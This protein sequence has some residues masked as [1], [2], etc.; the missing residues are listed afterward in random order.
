MSPSTFNIT[1]IMNDKHLSGKSQSQEQSLGKYDVICG[2]HKDAFDNVGNRRFRVLI[3]LSVSKYVHAPSR[4][5]KSAVIKDIVDSIHTAGGRFL[6]RPKGVSTCKW[7]ELDEKQTYD[8]IGH[9]FRDMSV[10]LKVNPDKRNVS[11]QSQ[12]SLSP[13]T[14]SINLNNVRSQS[15]SSVSQLS[16]TVK[17]PGFISVETNSAIVDVSSHIS[18]SVSLSNYHTYDE[19]VQPKPHF[20]MNG[21]DDD[22]I[23]IVLDGDFEDWTYNSMSCSLAFQQCSSQDSTRQ[24]QQ[25]RDS[26]S[27]FAIAS[28]LLLM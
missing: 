12:S 3:A 27:S 9:T 17:V 2:R 7:E 28:S 6:Q 11:C 10:S 20:N 13:S 14:S 26:I 5:H 24:E 23:S 22:E 19:M 21:Y 4:A 16:T 15:P 8:K 25:H 18:T 1:N